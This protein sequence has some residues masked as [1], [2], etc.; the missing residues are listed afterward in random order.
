MYSHNFYKR[1]SYHD[2]EGP[3]MRLD[4]RDR[5]VAS[6]GSENQAPTL[7]NHAP[8]PVGRTIPEAFIRFWRLNRA[9][10]IQLAA[11]AAK[12]RLPSAE[13]CEAS[14]AMGEEFLPAQAAP[15]Q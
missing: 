9:C 3:S 7:R 6:F 13:V 1:L 10:E 2:F 11:Q 15:G 14:F 5:L 8:L 4:E 12:L